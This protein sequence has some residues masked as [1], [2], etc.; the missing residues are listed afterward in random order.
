MTTY[1]T[2]SDGQAAFERWRTAHNA[3]RLLVRCLAQTPAALL[4]HAESDAEWRCWYS[5][6]GWCARERRLV[7]TGELRDAAATPDPAS[8]LMD[9]KGCAPD[10]CGGVPSEIYIR[11]QRDGTPDPAPLTEDEREEMRELLGA[12]CE[13]W[14]ELAHLIPSASW[15]MTDIV[16]DLVEDHQRM[17][18]LMRRDAADR[19]ESS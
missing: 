4:S 11:E 14:P 12:W 9:L 18:D 8:S 17:L 1:T 3:E 13:Q 16:T 6:C 15:S 2:P 5:W 10:I 7:G 19:E